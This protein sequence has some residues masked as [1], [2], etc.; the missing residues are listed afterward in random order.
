MSDQTGLFAGGQR[1]R[2]MYRDPSGVEE[3]TV[4]ARGSQDEHPAHGGHDDDGVIRGESAVVARDASAFSSLN[5]QDLLPSRRAA[6]VTSP[7][8][9]QRLLIKMGAAPAPPSAEDIADRENE[10]APPVCGIAAAISPI[11]KVRP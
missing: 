5:D 3:A 1:A 4:Q 8:P 9:W 2:E 10:Y 7:G 6:E 11:E